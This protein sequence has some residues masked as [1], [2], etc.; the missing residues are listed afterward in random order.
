MKSEDDATAVIL[1][2]T[3]RREFDDALGWISGNPLASCRYINSQ[4]VN[5]PEWFTPLS[6][7]EWS[8]S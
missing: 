1:A 3:G 4:P 5:S 6:G 8:T 7:T 2:A